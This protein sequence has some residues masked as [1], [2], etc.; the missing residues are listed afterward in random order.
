MSASVRSGPE[1]AP[2]QRPEPL[3][4]KPDLTER[5][6]RALQAFNQALGFRVEKAY[7]ENEQGLFYVIDTNKAEPEVNHPGECIVGP[8]SIGVAM[9]VRRQEAARAIL[10]FVDRGL[11]SPDTATHP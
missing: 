6:E 8:V 10:D 5:E 4:R 9:E 7:A 2:H 3:L 11:L 1:G